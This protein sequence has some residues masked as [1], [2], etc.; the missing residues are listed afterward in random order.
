MVAHFFTFVD[1]GTL[2]S[3]S[4]ALG[5]ITINVCTFI[6]VCTLALDTSFSFAS[7]CTTCVSTNGCSTP[8]SSF[9]FSMCIGSIDVAPGLA[10]SFELQ[11]RLHLHKNSI[12][13][14]P[15]IYISW[16]IVCVNCIFSL[17]ALPF[18]HS[19]NDGECDDNLITNDW[20]FNILM[21]CSSF[22]HLCSLFC[23]SFSLATFY[24]F[25]IMLST[26]MFLW[27]P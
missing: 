25:S 5:Y 3:I 11:P 26:L 14:V 4:I 12:A 18:S 22:L 13:D 8:S 20:M 23:A 16:I 15:I 7:Y 2:I 27:I 1:Y 19:E 21:H 10:C 17:Y 6:N 9:D 24:N